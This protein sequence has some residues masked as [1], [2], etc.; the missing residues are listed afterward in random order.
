MPA[1]EMIEL[2]TE[3]GI[4]L[5]SSEDE[6]MSDLSDEDFNQVEQELI[7]EIEE[8]GFDE[9]SIISLITPNKTNYN[10][11]EEDDA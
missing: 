3:K 7:K 11:E 6:S 4:V 1:S 5:V 10:S 8:G 9:G 2:E